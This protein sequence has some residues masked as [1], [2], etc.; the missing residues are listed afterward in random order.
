MQSQKKE[1]VSIMVTDAIKD[2]I[3]NED[4]KPGDKLYSENQLV[5]KLEVSRSSIREALRM[6]E[7]SGFVKVYQGKGVFISDPEQQL[8]PVKNWVVENADTLKE[9]FEV[10]LLIE[11]HAAAL[12][13]QNAEPKDLAALK[14]VFDSFVQEVEKGDVQK[15][16]GCDSAFH[17][18]IAKSTKNRTLAVLMRTMDKTLNEGWFASLHAPGRLQ[19]SIEE[20]KR[21]LDAILEHDEQKASLMMK[22][23]LENALADIQHYFGSL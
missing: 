3:K 21:L 5:K 13:C 6:L 16:I 11:P 7:V 22:K 10:R 4:L 14:S 20:H 17:L 19:T 1:R 12:A 23:H 9:L 15:A 8:Q 18:A 2:I